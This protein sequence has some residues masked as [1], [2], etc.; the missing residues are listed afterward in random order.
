MAFQMRV[1]RSRSEG[2]DIGMRNLC[3]K[4]YGKMGLDEMES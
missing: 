1:W 4:I 3:S 2:R